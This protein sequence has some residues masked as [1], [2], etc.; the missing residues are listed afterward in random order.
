M[1]GLSIIIPVLNEEEKIGRLLDQIHSETDKKLTQI[2]VVDGGSRDHTVESCR[3]HGVEPLRTKKPG[4]AHQMNMGARV[5][6][7]E[8]LFFVHVDSVLPKGWYEEIERILKQDVA[9]CFR[10]A[11]DPQNP[12]LRFY[13]WFTRFKLKLL[14]FGDQGLFIRKPIFESIGAFDEKLFLME[15][16]EIYKRILKVGKYQISEM[17]LTTSARKYTLT[18][19]IKTQVIF[20]IILGLFYLGVSQQVLKH[21]HQSVFIK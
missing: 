4:R 11:F 19:S 10:L 6:K 1:D 5:A 21:F 2:I 3:L 17:T 18:G 7:Y 14:R 13:S 16:Q 12:I 8:K 15:D 20:A 9:G